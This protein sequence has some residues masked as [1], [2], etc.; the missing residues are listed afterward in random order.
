VAAG[1]VL[2]FAL[3]TKEMTLVLL[4]VYAVSVALG[5][6][7]RRQWRP[8]LGAVRTIG[9]IAA[10]TGGWWYVRNLALYGD[11]LA[12]PLHAALY[13]AFLRTGPDSWGDAVALTAIGAHLVLFVKWSTI[14]GGGAAHGRFFTAIIPFV[15]AIMVGGFSVLPPRRV[16]ITSLLFASGM[17]VLGAL[18]PLLV[19]APAYRPPVAT[20]ADTR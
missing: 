12:Q 16:P 7:Q 3:L 14:I 20:A 4:P 6:R 10:L 1:L 13:A 5:A 11:F 17:A 9:A 19:I 18:T 8:E 2:G 15:A